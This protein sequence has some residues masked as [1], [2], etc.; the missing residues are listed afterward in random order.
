[1]GLQPGALFP[2]LPV[3]QAPFNLISCSK[4]VPGH[5]SLV[6]NLNRHL[7]F[8]PLHLRGILGIRNLKI[9]NIAALMKL[10]DYLLQ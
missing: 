3:F 5:G 4:V 6:K 7:F 2:I 8:S 10:R 9:Q 1:M